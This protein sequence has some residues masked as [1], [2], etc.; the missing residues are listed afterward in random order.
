M[1]KIRSPSLSLKMTALAETMSEMWKLLRDCGWDPSLPNNLTWSPILTVEITALLLYLLRMIFS[2]AR[3]SRLKVSDFKYNILSCFLAKSW[4][5]GGE[6]WD[7]YCHKCR[8]S[9][10]LSSALSHIYVLYFYFKNSLCWRL[11]RPGMLTG[12][13]GRVSWLLWG[14]SWLW[15][16]VAW[17]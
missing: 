9:L 5:V 3:I 16:A 7:A 14:E 2:A 15:G 11:V 12:R 4:S 6:Q 13:R 10:I 17:L 1:M 8:G